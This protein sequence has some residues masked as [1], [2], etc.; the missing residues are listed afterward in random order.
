MK[1]AIP[2]E[3]IPFL[4]AQTLWADSTKPRERQDGEHKIK[5]LHLVNVVLVEKPEKEDP[6]SRALGGDSKPL[7]VVV[8]ALRTKGQ[9]GCGEPE[10]KGGSVKT[11]SDYCF[12]YDDLQEATRDAQFELDRLKQRTQ[13]A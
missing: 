3:I 13:T 5:A 10:C 11:D 1:Q 12:V 6:L 7:F 4:K 9:C 2:S 8:S